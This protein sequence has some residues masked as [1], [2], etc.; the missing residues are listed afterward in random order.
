MMYPVPSDSRIA[1]RY[2]QTYPSLAF[3][4]DI[5]TPVQAVRSG[6]VLQVFRQ[7]SGFGE[8]VVIDHGSGIQTSYY[9]LQQNTAQV[10]SGGRV[11]A[12]Q[13]IGLSG[14]T[15]SASYPQLRFSVTVNGRFINP[16]RMLKVLSRNQENLEYQMHT[17]AAGETLTA[18]SKKHGT[19]VP[20][21]KK[22][23]GLAKAGDISP[24]QEI[25]I[26]KQT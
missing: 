23:N 16:E 5:G 1:K 21:L 24:G 19:T 15:G 25:K 18:I 13:T 11:K 7:R 8:A 10:L 20:A 22:L 26:R 6:T 12:G 4:V 9:H 3:R 17:V 14:E 2:S